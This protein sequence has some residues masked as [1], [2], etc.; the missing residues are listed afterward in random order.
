M[1]GQWKE[2]DSLRW[3]ETDILIFYVTSLLSLLWQVWKGLMSMCLKS[4]EG[5]LSN[6][7][8]ACIDK[9]D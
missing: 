8:I 1:K 2:T 9:V 3:K 6:R 5:L 4:A 7:P